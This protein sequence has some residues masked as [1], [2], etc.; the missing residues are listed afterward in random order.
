MKRHLLLSL[1]LL[2]VLAMQAQRRYDCTIVLFLEDDGSVLFIENRQ[3]EGQEEKEKMPMVR[4]RGAVTA[5]EERDT[6]RALILH[7]EAH[8]NMKSL[9]VLVARRDRKSVV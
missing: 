5:R 4:V 3:Y 6:L 9:T 2:A 7:K 8:D 1:F